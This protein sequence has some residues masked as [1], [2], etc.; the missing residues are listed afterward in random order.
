[1][2]VLS[3]SDVSTASQ[4]I[5]AHGVHVLLEVLGEL[6]YGRALPILDIIAQVVHR[7]RMYDITYVCM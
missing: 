6:P 4:T 7:A 1:M 3:D 2:Q 5:N